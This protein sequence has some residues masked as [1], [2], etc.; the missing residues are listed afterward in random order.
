VAAA[1]R[2]VEGVKSRAKTSSPKTSSATTRP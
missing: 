1:E 2:I